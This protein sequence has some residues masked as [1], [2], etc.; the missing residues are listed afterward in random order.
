MKSA[1]EVGLSDQINAEVAAG[2]CVGAVGGAADFLRAVHYSQGGLPIVALSAGT[3][4][5]S[6][7]DPDL[8]QPMSRQ[9]PRQCWRIAG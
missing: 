8:P 7:R 1:I 5:K 3:A 2:V 6:R 4:R 9:D